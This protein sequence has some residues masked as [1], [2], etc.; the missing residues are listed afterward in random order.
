ML[1][2]D[3]SAESESFDTLKIYKDC[4]DGLNLMHVVNDFFA[5]NDHRKVVFSNNFNHLINYV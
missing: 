1:C 2:K 3:V 4:T 5:G